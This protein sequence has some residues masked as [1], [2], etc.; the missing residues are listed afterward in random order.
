[1]LDGVKCFTF[2]QR[3]GGCFPDA[4]DARYVEHFVASLQQ[5]LLENR[6]AFL[7]LDT[8]HVELLVSLVVTLLLVRL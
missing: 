3:R 6:T 4:L 8:W 1:M 5:T 7:K 2:I